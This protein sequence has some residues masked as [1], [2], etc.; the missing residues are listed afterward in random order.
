MLGFQFKKTMNMIASTV[1]SDMTS[2]ILQDTCHVG[3]EFLLKSL[4]NQ[5]NPVFGREHL[6]NA[7]LREGLCHSGLL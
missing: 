2:Q 6:V 7:Y 5:R 1:Q 4:I 3:M